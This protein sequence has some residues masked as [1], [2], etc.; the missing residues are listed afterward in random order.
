MQEVAECRV[1]GRL[2]NDICEQ[3]ANLFFMLSNPAFR[4]G[5]RNRVNFLGQFNR[6]VEKKRLFLTLTVN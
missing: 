1:P 6:Q 5:L 3:V 2:N 4:L